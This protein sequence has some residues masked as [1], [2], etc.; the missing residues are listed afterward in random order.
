MIGSPLPRPTG[1]TILVR[2]Y[3]EEHEEHEGNLHRRKVSR[4]AVT[5]S[6]GSH[7]PTLGSLWQEHSSPRK[8]VSPEH[9]ALDPFVRF[10]PF[11]VSTL[12]NKRSSEREPAV[13]LR[14]KSNLI[15]GWLPS[16]T[17]HAE[18]LPWSTDWP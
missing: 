17:F 5:M 7:V 3:H 2:V 8:A 15:G 16:L 18:P 1:S 4:P 6:T 10:V 9:Y 14:H 12:S 11:V 13:S